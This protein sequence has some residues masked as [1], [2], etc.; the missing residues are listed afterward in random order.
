MSKDAH[1]EPDADELIS[2]QNDPPSV[3]NSRTRTGISRDH[4]PSMLRLITRRCPLIPRPPL[5]PRI[6]IPRRLLPPRSTDGSPEI[7]RCG[8]FQE[9]G[10][11]T[12]RV[13]YFESLGE[14]LRRYD[15]HEA[16]REHQGQR[17][18]LHLPRLLFPH[19]QIDIYYDFKTENN[20]LMQPE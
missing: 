15:V 12:D 18:S 10:Y 7:P 5:I 17:V 4:L 14:I 2:H 9:R 3:P 19:K 13:Q 8:S 11:D 16:V 20:H 1:I 6:L